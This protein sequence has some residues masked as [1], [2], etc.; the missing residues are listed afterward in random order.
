MACKVCGE[1]CQCSEPKPDVSPQFTDLDPYDPSEEQFASSLGEVTADEH[2]EEE[3]EEEPAL[4]A[5]STLAESLHRGRS[6]GPGE[7]NQIPNFVSSSTASNPQ[8]NEPASWKQE[9]SS[10][11]SR[12]KARRREQLGQSSL[13]FNFESTTANHVFLQREGEPAEVDAVDVFSEE[14]IADQFLAPT[15]MGSTAPELQL[16]TPPLDMTELFSQPTKVIDESA[17]ASIPDVGK[18]IE[19]PRAL[20][21]GPTVNPN[22]LAE[23]VLETPRIL[24]VPDTIAPPPPPLSDIE[25]EREADELDP[26]SS[27][28]ALDV[29]PLPQRIFAGAVDAILVLGATALFGAI[30]LKIAGPVLLADRRSALIMI[31]AVP[32]IL[33][34]M[35]SYLLLVHGG[36]TVGMLLARLRL[37]SF[38]MEPVGRNQ[39]KFRVF[40]MQLSCLALAMGL[41]WAFIDEDQICWHDRITHTY[42]SA[43]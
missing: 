11:L 34:A 23:P 20:F 22:E 43:R 1:L 41:I 42:L 4:I 29:A 38:E 27:E 5:S 24:D 13:N 6:S 3:F 32:A 26:R 40:A 33:W 9:L 21:L 15:T 2:E 25:L 36:R 10:R 16:S 17:S 37:V 12:Y 28:P 39:R 8:P 35:Y 7:M 31:A 14:E 19:F 18:L 30:A